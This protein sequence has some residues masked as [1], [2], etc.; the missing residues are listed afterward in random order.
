MI[1]RV[2]D[3][4][5]SVFA[6]VRSGGG[7]EFICK[8]SSLPSDRDADNGRSRQEDHARKLPRPLL[9]PPLPSRTGYEGT[10]WGGGW[11]SHRWATPDMFPTYTHWLVWESNPGID[12]ET[13]LAQ[14]LWLE[15]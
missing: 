11:R 15:I 7:D 5:G 4:E 2:I 6:C 12:S 14:I 13:S 3:S 10:G 8:V 1:Q 9:D